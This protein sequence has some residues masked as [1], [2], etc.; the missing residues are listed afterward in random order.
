MGVTRGEAFAGVGMVAGEEVEDTGDAS[1][2][3]LAGGGAVTGPGL[4]P[5][6]RR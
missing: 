2:A 6:R 4:A 5:G 1:D 3:P